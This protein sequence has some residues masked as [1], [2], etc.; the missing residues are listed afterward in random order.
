MGACSWW[1]QDPVLHCKTFTEFSQ[2]DHYGC[3]NGTCSDSLRIGAISPL[4]CKATR[5]VSK[6]EPHQ[7]MQCGGKTAYQTQAPAAAAT[8]C[9]VPHFVQRLS[10]H[11]LRHYSFVRSLNKGTI[12]VWHSEPASETRNLPRF[13]SE[14][15]HRRPLHYLC[16]GTWQDPHSYQNVCVLRGTRRDVQIV[17]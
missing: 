9:S 17:G 16:Y 14:L 11:V 3:L 13:P 12:S 2:P 7:A 4:L 6:V 5:H 1:R 15:R 10:G 8:S